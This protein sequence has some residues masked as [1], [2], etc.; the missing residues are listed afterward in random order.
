[1]KK[2]VVLVSLISLFI[3]VAGCGSYGKLRLQSGPGE[4]TT[5]QELK[6]NWEKY[7]I[8]ATGVEANVPSAIIFDRKDDGREIIG[9]RWWE[10]KDY[11]WVSETIDRIEAQGSTGGGYYPRLWKMLGPDGH[12]YGYMFTAWDKAVMP[13]NNDKTM[14]VLDLPMPPFLAVNGASQVRDPD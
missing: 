14:A 11:K 5:T 4:T 8:L 12:L 1:M 10:L 3:I 7:H 6:E 9:E 2:G 13:V